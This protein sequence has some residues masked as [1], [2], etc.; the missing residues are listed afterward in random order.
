MPGSYLDILIAELRDEIDRHVAAFRDGEIDADQFQQRMAR[1]LTEHHVAVYLAGL[2]ALGV[3][4]V[5]RAADKRVLAELIGDQIDYLN[6]FADVL[7]ANEDGAWSTAYE[8]RARMYAGSLT[9][10]YWRGRTRGYRL[11]FMPGEGTLCLVNCGCSWEISVPIA[12]WRRGKNDS[13]A[14]C[15]GREAGNPYTLEAA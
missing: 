9:Q 8:A 14:T 4:Q 6:G 2:A 15:V 11:P 5:I 7:A 12:Y 13:C 1:D 3:A 10:T